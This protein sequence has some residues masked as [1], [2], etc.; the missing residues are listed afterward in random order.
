MAITGSGTEQDPYLVAT[1]QDIAEAVGRVN[2]GAGNYIKL[3]ADINCN[4]Y[5]DAFEWEGLGMSYNSRWF[6]FD[7]D[8]HTIKNVKVKTNSLF[9]LGYQN[10][11]NTIRNGKLLNVF[12][13]GATEFV[14]RVN[15][16]KLSISLDFTGMSS[17]GNVFDSMVSI[18]ECAIYVQSGSSVS[19]L[20]N[21]TNNSTKNFE[22]SD[23]LM[24]VQKF[25]DRM[26]I[27]AY[28]DGIRLRGNMADFGSM[29]PS[30][31]CKYYN[32][33]CNIA[34]G[35]T[36]PRQQIIYG[37]SPQT[38]IEN[39]QITGLDPTSVSVIPV[40]S[41]EIINGDALRAKSF[42]VVNVVGD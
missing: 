26:I 40:N 27:S 28:T 18:K 22:N 4:D 20:I 36:S 39:C 7:L 32:S 15:L 37:G 6:Y 31:N 9:M 11:H 2:S 41:E 12:L 34:V 8:G 10:D 29:A 19:R 16:E 38:C 30:Y 13:S 3:T 25:T 21:F 1:Y 23:I 42:T 14:S 24:N 33:V 35:G 5:G 17:N